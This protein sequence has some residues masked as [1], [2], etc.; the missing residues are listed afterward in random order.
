MPCR[1]EA[2]EP[3][4]VHIMVCNKT[5]DELDV[6]STA[7][8]TEVRQEEGLSLKWKGNSLWVQGEEARVMF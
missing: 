2:D 5:S 3:F 1:A 8:E 4:L 7:S 6:G